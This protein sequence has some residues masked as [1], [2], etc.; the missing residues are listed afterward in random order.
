MS[1]S[2]HL[3]FY[4]PPGYAHG[5][6]VLSDVADFQYKCTDFYYPDDQGEVLWCDPEIGIDWPITEPLLSDKD[7]DAPLLKDM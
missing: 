5:F 1:G 3:Q 7:R 2:N 4:V 6:V